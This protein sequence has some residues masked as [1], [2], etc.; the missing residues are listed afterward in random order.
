M[1]YVVSCYSIH[2]YIYIYGRIILYRIAAKLIRFFIGT[3]NTLRLS[4]RCRQVVFSRE[5]KQ[6]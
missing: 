1:F 2:I 3:M 5:N 4:V 6:T